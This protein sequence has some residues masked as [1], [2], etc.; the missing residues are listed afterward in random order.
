MNQKKSDEQVLVFEP[1]KPEKSF[2]EGLNQYFNG[3]YQ[4]AADY[5]HLALE[6][7]MSGPDIE[8]TLGFVHL[9]MDQFSRAEACFKEVLSKYPAEIDARLGLGEVYYLTGNTFK[10]EDCFRAV[11]AG[12]QENA[13]AWN[14][15]GV[16]YHRQNNY[17][18]AK[19]Y[20]ETAIEFGSV[21]S[22]FH[23]GTILMEEDELEKAEEILPIA[24]IHHVISCLIMIS[25]H[26][27]LWDKGGTECRGYFM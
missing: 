25:W 9:S 21:E 4:L 12:D 16:I 18:R 5:L 27:L 3:N 11:L 26:Q 7:G 6:S 19:I 8:T 20:Y 15:L 22:R 23:L 17:N 13:R 10:A 1:D 2:E 14:D 24:E